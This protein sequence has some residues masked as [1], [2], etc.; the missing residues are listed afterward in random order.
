MAHLIASLMRMRHSPALIWGILLVLLM[1]IVYEGYAVFRITRQNTLISEPERIEVD[2]KTPPFLVFAKARQ[3]EQSGEPQEALRLY[4]SILDR[5][6]EQLREHVHYNL[7]TLYLRE[8]AALWNAKGVLE[9]VRVNTL[10]ALAKEQLQK[11]L[12]LNPDNWDARFNLEYAYR[13]TPP[14]KER[15]KADW[16]GAKP[17]VFATVPTIPGGAP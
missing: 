12:R 9:Y 14:A 15:E 17:S 4:A 6:D 10:V 5:G 2:D 1:G 13:I 16:H 11:A 8:A 3:L 7:G